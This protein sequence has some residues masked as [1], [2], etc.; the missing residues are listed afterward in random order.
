MRRS[1][2]NPILTRQDIPEIWPQLADVTSVFNPG[3]IRFGDEDVLMLRVQNRARETFFLTARSTDGT[4]FHV[5]HEIIH[6]HGIEQVRETVYHVYDARIT[7]LGGVY[8]LMFAMDMDAGCRLGL[9][10]TQ[11]FR[12]FEFL[13]MVSDEDTRN[14]VLF[15]EKISGKYLRLERPNTVKLE[16]GPTSGS[17]I[18]LGESDDLL[19]WKPVAPIISGRYHFWDELIGAGPPPI[20]TPYGWLNIYHG[21]ATHFGSSNIYQAG[22]FL[23]DL[24]DPSKVLG[25]GKYNILE[26]RESYELVGQVPNVVFPSGAIVRDVDESGLADS[27]SEVLIYYGGAD[28][29]VGLATSTVRE[30]ITATGFAIPS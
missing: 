16:G 20:K 17:T 29:V 21:I 2:S 3:A 10:S 23:L 28:T 12:R 11:D 5:T 7:Q 9:A 8:Y 30:L 6:L 22:V 14:G 25:R 13:G 27:E 4:H 19:R 1:S 26:P 18:W 24:A 15:P